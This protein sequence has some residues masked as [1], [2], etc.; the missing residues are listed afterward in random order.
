VNARRR[1]IKEK[2]LL[3]YIGVGLSAGLLGLLV[4]LAALVIGVPLAAGATPMTILTG[5]MEPTYPPGTLI[6]V[7]PI[8]TSDIAIGDPIT[9]QLESGRPEVVTH[10]VVSIASANGELTFIT[11][12]DANNAPDAKPVMPVQIRGTVWYSVPLIGYVNTVVNGENRGW[13]VPAI[14]IALFSYAGYM[15]ASGIVHAARRRRRSVETRLASTAHVPATH[16]HAPHSS[17]QHP[18]EFTS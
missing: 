10:R 16:H 14:A 18:R 4:M 11:K 9:Y 5:S 13:I 6:I 1:V 2:G 12:G 17:M 7:K 15:F 3:H 8:A